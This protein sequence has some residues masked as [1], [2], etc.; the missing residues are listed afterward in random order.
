MNNPRSGHT[1]SELS[2]GRII[3]VGGISETGFHTTSEVHDSST[4]EWTVVGEMATVR[5]SHATTALP[6]GRVLVT[7]GFTGSASVSLM[8]IY[9][10]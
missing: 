5:L 8:E 6:D 1:L 10:P 4:Q 3:V 9:T 7:G 2:D